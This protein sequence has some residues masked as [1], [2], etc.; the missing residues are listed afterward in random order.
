MLGNPE[1]IGKDAAL[2]VSSSR[3]G[4]LLFISEGGLRL[5]SPDG[6]EQ[7]I[8]WPVSY[9]PPVAQTTLIRNVRI[10]DGTGGP[11]TGPRDILIERGRIH[12]IAPAGTISIVAPQVIDAAGRFVIPGLID[13]HAHVYRGDL[14]SGF[15]YFGVTTIR[16]QGSS[17][18]PLVAYAD[19]IAAGLVA[20]PRIGYGGFQ[21]Y[22]DWPFD[23]RGPR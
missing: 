8:G 17:M 10:L 1:P 4:S 5:R 22:S 3:N 13:L 15:L 9:T 7:K 20:G 21:F 2:Y 12:R 16:D 19:G 23:E 6:N 11:V 14:L 18:A